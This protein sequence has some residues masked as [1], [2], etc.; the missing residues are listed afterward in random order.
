MKMSVSMLREMV[1]KEVTE[2][3]INDECGGGQRWHDKSGRWTSK[4]KATSWTWDDKDCEEHGQFKV[5][6]GKKTKDNQPCG[7]RDR[8]ALCRENE[9]EIGDIYTRERIENVI[10]KTIK[11]EL[12]A[13]RQSKGGCSWKQILNGLNQI[14]LAQS[15]KLYAKQKK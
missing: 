9:E 1:S 12:E 6:G 7:R 10:R 13:L 11:Q 4:D 15:G 8:K 2:K 14:D 5:V 3:L